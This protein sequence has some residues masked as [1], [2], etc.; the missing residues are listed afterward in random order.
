VVRRH[1]LTRL[2]RSR[3]VGLL[4][5]LLWWGLLP[6][7]RRGRHGGA[8]LLVEAVGRLLLLLLRGCIAGGVA[9]TTRGLKRLSQMRLLKIPS[10]TLW[11]EPL[12]H[13]RHHMGRNHHGPAAALPE[14]LPLT[15]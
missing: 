10:S 6:L 15:S 8:G 2:G 13:S 14:L 4:G 3:L 11:M 9:M 5:L 12:R 1:C 7:Y